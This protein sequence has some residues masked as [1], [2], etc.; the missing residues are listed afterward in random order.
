MSFK[1]NAK[2]F[3]FQVLDKLPNKMGDSLYHKIQEI[4]N[5]NNIDFKID[6]SKNT[7]FAFQH[8][9]NLLK[10]P[11]SGRTLIE[12]GSGWLPIMPYFL[13]Y[14][15]KMEKVVTYDLNKHYN[16]NS[17]T[18]L[19][20]LFSQKFEVKIDADEGEFPLPKNLGYYPNTNI[21]DAKLPVAEIVFSRFVLEHIAPRDIT[22]IHRKLKNELKPGSHIIHFI[23]PGDHRA[24]VDES[25][26]L[27]DFLKYSE[28]EWKKKHTRFDY[29]NRLRLPEYIEIFESLGLEII[30]LEFSNPPL[31]SE[32]YKLFKRVDLHSDY[33]DFSEEELTAGAINIVLKT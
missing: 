9:A 8:I 17:I 31:D 4:S 16:Q 2:T 33:K 24:Y 25:L 1:L 15:G 22:D 32:M 3:L 29:H 13:L 20:S 12:I 30:H 11:V 7:Y 23:S 19:N 21:V 6:S 18:K 14:L 10:I 5:G 26:S 28:A 27:Q